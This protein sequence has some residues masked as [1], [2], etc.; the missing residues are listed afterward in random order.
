MVREW[1]VRGFLLGLCTIQL[2]IIQV[3]SCKST[4]TIGM[5]SFEDHSKEEIEWLNGFPFGNN[6]WKLF[7][8]LIYKFTTIIELTGNIMNELKLRKVIWFGSGTIIYIGINDIVGEKIFQKP[9]DSRLTPLI[10]CGSNVFSKFLPLWKVYLKRNWTQSTKKQSDL[11]VSG[12]R[13]NRDWRLW[14]V[15]DYFQRS[16]SQPIRPKLAVP[17]ASAPLEIFF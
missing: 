4:P 6:N 3:A 13:S 12:R 7:T 8:A 9:L 14:Q 10:S 16:F 11:R 1:Y 2:S 15:A 17:K 5:T